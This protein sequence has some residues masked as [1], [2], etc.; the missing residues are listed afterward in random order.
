MALL[1]CLIRLGKLRPQLLRWF[2]VLLLLV[3]AVEWGTFF[4][5]YKINNSNNWIFNLLNAFQFIFY[6][7]I[8]Y[9][10]LGSARARKYVA[11]SCV[12]LVL[13]IGVNIAFLQGIRSFNSYTFIAGCACTVYWSYLYLMQQVENMETPGFTNDPFFWISIG[14]MIFH[15]GEFF[16]MSFFQ[17]FS[18]INEFGHFF[19]VFSVCSNL[20]NAILYTCLTIAFFCR[21]TPQNLL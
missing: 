12:I 13:A 21:R 7:G 8:Y 19:S 11:A 4:R 16:L 5:L 3:N 14:L 9:R 18:A 2:L 10:L 15:A 1:A 6:A 20:L 17:Y